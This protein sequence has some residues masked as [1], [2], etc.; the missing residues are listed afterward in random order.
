MSQHLIEAA[1]RACITLSNAI[2]STIEGA[3]DPA[4]RDGMGEVQCD[5]MEALNILSDQLTIEM[6]QDAR[7]LVR[8]LIVADTEAWR[9]IFRA[10]FPGMGA[11]S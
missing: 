5:L 2:D 1:V 7:K 3:A 6:G 8:D 10:R 9:A 4:L 11:Q